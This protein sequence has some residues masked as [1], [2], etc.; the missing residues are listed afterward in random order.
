MF[1]VSYME[2]VHVLFPATSEGPKDVGLLVGQHNSS[3]PPSYAVHWGQPG[4]WCDRYLCQ[5]FTPK[6][7]NIS[8]NLIGSE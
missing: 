8:T 6:H 5:Q 7:H 1:K 4:E 2:V 3:V